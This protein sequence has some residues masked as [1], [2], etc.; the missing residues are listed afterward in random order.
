MNVFEEPKVTCDS[1][2]MSD[3][4]SYL[5]S[6][7]YGKTSLLVSWLVS[8][9]VRTKELWMEQSLLCVWRIILYKETKFNTGSLWKLMNVLFVKWVISYIFE[10]NHNIACHVQQHFASCIK[11]TLDENCPKNC[12][13]LLR[14]V[15]L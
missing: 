2:L 7:C 4:F 6:I 10:K 5:C 13:N 8:D 12:I 15:R 9:D 3:R 11:V 14:V 1:V